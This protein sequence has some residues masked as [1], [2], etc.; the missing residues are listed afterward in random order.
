MIGNALSCQIALENLNQYKRLNLGAKMDDIG[1]QIKDLLLS[2]KPHI[3][4]M[5]DVRGPGAMIAIE[6]ETKEASDELVSI[7]FNA[8]SDLGLSIT[9]DM[10]ESSNEMFGKDK[11]LAK[12]PIELSVDSRVTISAPNSSLFA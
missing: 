11:V 6:M 3:Q 7:L 8:G 12:P 5:I 9:P 2:H 4:T 10:I 1:N